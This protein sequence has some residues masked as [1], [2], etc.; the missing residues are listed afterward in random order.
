MISDIFNIYDDVNDNHTENVN[1]QYDLQKLDNLLD[2]ILENRNS[3]IV[4]KSTDIETR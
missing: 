3:N 1:F 4:Y 2:S